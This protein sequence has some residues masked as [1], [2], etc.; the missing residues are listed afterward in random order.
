MLNAYREVV[1][2]SQFEALKEE[3]A[4]LRR[5]TPKVKDHLDQVKSNTRNIENEV[6]FLMAGVENAEEIK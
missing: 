1:P 6:N 4:K 3:N 2:K 5:D